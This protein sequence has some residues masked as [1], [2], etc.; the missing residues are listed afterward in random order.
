MKKILG[1]DENI[2]SKYQQSLGE[3]EKLYGS[4]SQKAFKGELDL[5]GVVKKKNESLG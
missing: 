3:L 4:L 2:K 1:K 5:S